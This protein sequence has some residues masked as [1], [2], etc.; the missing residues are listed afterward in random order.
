MNPEVLK[1]NNSAAAAV[2]TAVEVNSTTT[3]SKYRGGSQPGCDKNRNFSVPAKYDQL[4]RDL[5]FCYCRGI[6]LSTGTEFE[7]TD[8]MQRSIYG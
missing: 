1:V 5:F 8:W 6:P 3:E 2:V 7:G 4:E